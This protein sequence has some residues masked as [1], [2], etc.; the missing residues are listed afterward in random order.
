[1]ESKATYIYRFL[2]NAVPAFQRMKV[3]G[4][5]SAWPYTSNSRALATPNNVSFVFAM[6]KIS[7]EKST[8]R[9]LYICRCQ[10]LWSGVEAGNVCESYAIVSRNAARKKDAPIEA[11]KWGTKRLCLL[12]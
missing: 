10:R 2:S 12:R 1:V 9:Y 11:Q 5:P 4:L 8:K 6:I 3:H 7:C